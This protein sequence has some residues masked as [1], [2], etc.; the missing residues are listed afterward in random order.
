MATFLSL[1]Q[2]S[3]GNE[4]GEPVIVNMD[5][6]MFIATPYGTTHSELHFTWVPI[7]HRPTHGLTEVLR[8]VESQ[9]AIAKRLRIARE[10][11]EP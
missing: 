3:F 5:Q 8:V 7:E 1:H 9:E 6:V 11:M 10:R 4:S 2:V